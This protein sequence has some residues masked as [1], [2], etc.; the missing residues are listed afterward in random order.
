MSADNLIIVGAIAGA[1]GTRG[2]VRLKSFCAVPEDIGTYGTLFSEDGSKEYEITIT[3]PVKNGFA[4]KVKGV[5]FKDQAD[6]LRGVSLH[7]SRETLPN[8]PDDEFY[9][10]DLI[11]LEVFDTGGVKL[12]R[13]KSILDHGAGDIL[14]VTGPGLKQPAL[15]PFTKSAI[16]TVDLTSGRVVADPPLGVF[17]DD[18]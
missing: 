15:L 7:V 6:A 9:H 13:F 2:E 12:G 3:R 18:G 14:E 1:F 16:P 5:R 8:L 10:S 17:P 4:A 11:G